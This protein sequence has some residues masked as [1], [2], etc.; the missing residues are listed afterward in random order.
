M[1]TMRALAGIALA[2]IC[3]PAFAQED[4]VIK[5][6]VNLVNLFFT[7]KNKGGGLVANLEKDAFQVFENGQKQTI[8]TAERLWEDLEPEKDFSDLVEQLLV[9]F[10][11]TQHQ[12]NIRME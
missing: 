3:L 9:K 4:S 8:K 10:I 1:V 2:A 6:D 11:V 12:D 7:V 5:V